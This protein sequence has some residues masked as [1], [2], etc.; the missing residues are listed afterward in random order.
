MKR[1]GSVALVSVLTGV[2][3]VGVIGGSSGSVSAAYAGPPA[4]GPALAIDSRYDRHAI[5]PDIYGWNFAPAAVIKDLGLTVDRWGG[6][7]TVT[8]NWQNDRY[9]NAANYYWE[10][11]YGT[12]SSDKFPL[13]LAKDRSNAAH[14]RT[15][16][17]LPTLGYVSGTQVP[18][19]QDDCS[20]PRSKYPNQQE[21]DQYRT[22]CGNGRAPDGS[23]LTS[24]NPA[25]IARPVDASFDKG[26]VQSL[27][28]TYGSALHGGVGFYA[29]D[30]EPGIWSDTHRDIH[31]DPENY[32]E[33][34]SKDIPVA[35]AVKQV[36]PTAKVLGPSG[37]GFYEMIYSGLDAA[38]YAAGSQ[39]LEASSHGNLTHGQWFLSQMKQ[40]SDSAGHRLLDYFDEHLYPQANGV[41]LSKAGNAQTQ[42]LRLRQTRVLWDPKYQDES[43]QKDLGL[44]PLQMIRRM[45]S[46]VKT[47]FPGTKTAITEY[48]FGA[49][50][51]INGALAQADV[52]G[53]F[54]RE[55]LD[56]ANV[57]DGPQTNQP[58]YNAFRLYRNYDGHGA[59]FGE[60]YLRSTSADQGKLAV[61]SAARSADKR[62]TVMVLNKTGAAITSAMTVNGFTAHA[63]QRYQ[64]S[65]R[66]V[67]KIYNVT[68]SSDAVIGGK[69]TAT[70]PANSITLWII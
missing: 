45:K 53:I 15:L 9:N 44:G 60:S 55:G 25:T 27:Y 14:P 56:L 47:Y 16:L 43:W 66:D 8:Y 58:G 10:N 5:S 57:W 69:L 28:N 63:P 64:Y 61:Y 49:M 26:W 54:A 12:T 13:F 38:N 1:V 68:N 20:F 40:A 52:L 59:K 24:P 46:W 70:Y 36:D 17:T 51:S 34:T 4:T 7:D 22:N 37:W 62:V 67:R 31:P 32:D 48:N 2:G 6:D 42:A 21:F 33:L 18:G 30:N 65:G 11:N 19:D 23:P 50:E 39:T 41:A 29:L 35:Q 3:V